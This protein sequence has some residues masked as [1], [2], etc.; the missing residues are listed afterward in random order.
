MVAAGRGAGE[1]RERGCYTHRGAV[2]HA[3]THAHRLP[4]IYIYIY[5][6]QVYYWWYWWCTCAV[7][8]ASS[9]WHTGSPT[10]RRRRGVAT[11]QLQV[12]IAAAQVSLRRQ[13]GRQTPLPP[14]PPAPR[15]LRRTWKSVL[16][17]ALQGSGPGGTATPKSSR[18]ADLE[19]GSSGSSSGGGGTSG[20]RA[21]EGGRGEGSAATCTRQGGV[22]EWLAKEGVGGAVGKWG[23]L[24]GMADVNT[25][26]QQQGA[27]C[28]ASNARRTR[29]QRM[30]ALKLI[31]AGCSLRRRCHA[32]AGP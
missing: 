10:C 3:R 32:I 7:T 29:A 1:G 4:D 6:A 27:A 8:S 9:H 26:S 15:L 16:R 18:A 23:R 17:S 24:Q 14:G 12:Q 22:W 31:G 25:T 21:G 13:A 11:P 28:R 19:P 30:R 20:T 2:T 5:M